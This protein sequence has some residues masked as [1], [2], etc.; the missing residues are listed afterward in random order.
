MSIQEIDHVP[1]LSPKQLHAELDK[2]VA[3][4]SDSDVISWERNPHHQLVP[5][6]VAE[7][8]VAQSEKTGESV[9]D[10]LRAAV[11]TY[12]EKVS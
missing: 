2:A 4:Y 3:G 8:L 7:K 9:D 5:V 10:L 12:L 11:N 1:G 6:D